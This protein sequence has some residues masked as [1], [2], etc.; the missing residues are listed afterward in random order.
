MVEQCSI[1]SLCRSSLYYSPVPESNENL[2][3]MKFL[4]KQYFETSFYGVLSLTAL[5]NNEEYPVN[6]KRVRRLMK[7]V[8]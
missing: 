2:E 7:L 8:N 4:D 3:I 1:L 6:V 5:L